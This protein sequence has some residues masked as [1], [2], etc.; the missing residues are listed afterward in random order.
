MDP[1]IISL[2]VGG[3]VGLFG[4]GLN[5]FSGLNKAQEEQVE[6]SAQKEA[7]R[8]MREEQIR[9]QKAAAEREINYARSVFKIEQDDAF[10]K[11]GDIWKQAER[12]DNKSDLEETL[13]ERA[14][15]LAVKRD[16]IADDNALHTE[17]RGKQNFVQKQGQ[18]KTAL[19]LSGTRAGTNSAEALLSQ[20]AQNFEQDL[21]LMQNQR[22][23]ERDI[24][25]LGA[26]ASLRQGMLNIDESREA[27]NTAF[28]D[29]AQLRS[30]Y[31]DGGRATNLFN[32]K[33]DNRRADLQGNIDLQNLGGHFKQAALNRAYDRA[34]YSFLDGLTDFAGGFTSGFGT[35]TSITNFAQN[36]GNFGGT[37]GA[38]PSTANYRAWAEREMFMPFGNSGV[39]F[40]DGFY[41]IRKIRNPMG[42][43]F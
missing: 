28:R 1:F 41:D 32:Q 2:I 9:E 24:S 17:Q 30:D 23:T 22:K 5:I 7:E 6:I 37:G 8:K 11:A 40:G 26:W 42:L 3:V 39:R 14:F 15:N 33:I 12:I 38:A 35:G 31:S 10:K 21:L 16:K 18:M 27:A 36:W 13:T 34:E 20:D 43:P 4:G 25:L 29:S 19:G